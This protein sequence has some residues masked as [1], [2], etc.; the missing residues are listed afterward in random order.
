MVQVTTLLMTLEFQESAKRKGHF[1][2]YNCFVPG[3]YQIQ[4]SPTGLLQSISS[5][6]FSRQPS[7]GHGRD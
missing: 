2:L 7:L 6:T 5:Q 4:W 3:S 1:A